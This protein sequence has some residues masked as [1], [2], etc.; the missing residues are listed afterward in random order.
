MKFEIWTIFAGAALAAV[1]M[2]PLAAQQPTGKAPAYG[3]E[4][5]GFDYPFPVQRFA[6]TSAKSGLSDTEITEMRDAD[7]GGAQRGEVR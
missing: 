3:P 2:G 4:L 7:R 5:E 6:F 1:A